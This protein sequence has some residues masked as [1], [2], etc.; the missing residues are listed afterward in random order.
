MRMR[1]V[2]SY[3]GRLS[4]SI[5]QLVDE[6]ST[7]H[8]RAHNLIARAVGVAQTLFPGPGGRG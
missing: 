2:L 8:A 6:H 7:V 5:E 4:D 3:L 1:I